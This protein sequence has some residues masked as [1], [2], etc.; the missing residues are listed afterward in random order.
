MPCPTSPR[1]TSECSFTHGGQFQLYRG[2]LP[3]FNACFSTLLCLKASFMLTRLLSYKP[4]QRRRAKELMLPW[5]QSS[6]ENSSYPHIQL[7]HYWAFCWLFSLLVLLG[8]NAI[9]VQINECVYIYMCVF[10]CVYSHICMHREI[11]VSTYLYIF[12]FIYTYR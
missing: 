7:V 9:W 8:K 3:T 10:I 2:Q 11:T 12:L 5:V 4:E 6:A 1:L